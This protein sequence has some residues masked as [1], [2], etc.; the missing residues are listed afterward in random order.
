MPDRY[1]DGVRAL[2]TVDV[3]DQWTE[4]EARAA[5]GLIVPLDPDNLGG[6]GRRRW[7]TL[8]AAAAALVLVVGGVTLALRGEDDVRTDPTMTTTPTTDGPDTFDEPTPATTTPTDPAPGT[9]TPSTPAPS[10]APSDTGEAVP[11]L[12]ACPVDILMT[13]ST[14]PAGWSETM[15][16]ASEWL[17]PDPPEGTDPRLAGVFEG[18]TSADFVSVSAGFL[19]LQDDVFERFPGP[20]PGV[21]ALIGPWE[22]GWYLEVFVPRPAG[23]CWVTLQAIGMGRA[24]AVRFVGGLLVR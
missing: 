10:E 19:N 15:T 3:P 21:E 14:P 20:V 24:D 16:P 2:Q 9:E 12:T 18:P 11:D 6:R 4:M 22:G 8:L 23:N 13:T 5:T 7:P 1:E 17:P